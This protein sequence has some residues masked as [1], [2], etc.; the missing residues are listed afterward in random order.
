MFMAATL[1]VGGDNV[2]HAI[3]EG[4]RDTAVTGLPYGSE[5]TQGGHESPT[6]PFKSLTH[7]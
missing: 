7:S 2:E 3:V 6:H 4:G 5:P 1:F